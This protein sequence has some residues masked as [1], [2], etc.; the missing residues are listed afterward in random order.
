M[1]QNSGFQ[2]YIYINHDLI[3]NWPWRLIFAELRFSYNIFA[4]LFT[5]KSGH[6]IYTNLRKKQKNNYAHQS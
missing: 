5:W 4:K 1:V 2:I 3:D 6:E